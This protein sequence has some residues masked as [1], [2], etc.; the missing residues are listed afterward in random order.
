MTN[1]V[2]RLVTPETG[3]GVSRLMQTL[4]R[5]YVRYLNHTYR[6]SGTLWEGR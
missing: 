3:H 1:H 5:H 4:G 6:R 2:H